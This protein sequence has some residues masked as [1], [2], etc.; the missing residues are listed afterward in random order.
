MNQLTQQRN[1]VLAWALEVLDWSPERL[2]RMLNREL[3]TLNHHRRISRNSP[4]QWRDLNMVPRPPIPAITAHVLSQ[5]LDRPLSVHELWQGR[6]HDPQLIVPADFGLDQPWNP[7]GTVEILH[8][9][10]S[11]RMLRRQ[12]LSI[13]GLALTGPA[14]EWA[15]EPAEAAIA[16]THGDR[17]LPES[18]NLVDSTVAGL[19][20][21]DDSGGG[22]FV[23]G[24]AESQLSLVIDLLRNGRYDSS[25]ARRLHSTV[26]NLAQ[27]AG[28]V[29]QD[30]GDEAR[31]QRYYL[32]ALHAAH[33]SDDRAFGAR[34]LACMAS[35]AQRND[36]PQD[37]LVLID[38]ARRSVGIELTPTVQAMLAY[39]E[40]R[41]H[42]K[43][44]DESA[45]SVSLNSA[46][47]LLDKVRP[48]EDPPW[49]YWL[50][51]SPE[52]CMSVAAG[53]CYAAL[54][55][56]H[57]GRAE[58]Y[59]QRGTDLRAPYLRDRAIDLPSLAEVQR[60]R[61]DVE[62]ACATAAEALKLSAD[63]HTT[64]GLSALRDFRKRLSTDTRSPAVKDFLA[65][66]HDKLTAA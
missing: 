18:V 53:D 26:A 5:S 11:D 60:R 16:A 44:G 3:V 29:C 35:L 19:R 65:L 61:G 10:R 23:L 50:T 56:R 24:A 42:A 51:D 2:A 47:N 9:V 39:K 64:R 21:L 20:R 38:C 34:V 33:S 31:A 59:L 15:V 28:Y 32:T 4:A 40:A 41:L 63:T 37:A 27:L 48:E 14:M 43:L 6:A 25:L 22:S 30:H 17:V 12:F 7:A 52:G 46:E 45:C 36:R 55:D 57:L 1:P 49:I 13:S 66:S 58:R 62:A 8:T 54:G